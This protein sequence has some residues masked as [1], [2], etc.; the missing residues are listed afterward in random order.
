MEKGGNDLHLFPLINKCVRLLDP[1]GVT[2]SK[3]P[4]ITSLG[5]WFLKYRKI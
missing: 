4:D 1:K 2:D 5:S 3:Y